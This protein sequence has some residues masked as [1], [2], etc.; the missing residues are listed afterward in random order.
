MET[1]K[2]LAK[3]REWE[4]LFGKCHDAHIV[5][6]MKKLVPK[7]YHHILNNTRTFQGCLDKL[8]K[9]TAGE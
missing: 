3:I 2:L 4:K 1:N 6:Q 7:E 5:P 8:K 9:I